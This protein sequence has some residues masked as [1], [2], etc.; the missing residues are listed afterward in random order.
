L[1]SDSG[2]LAIHGLLNPDM[3]FD[4]LPW[5]PFHPGVDI[6]ELYPKTD[7]EGHAALLRYQPGTCVPF[8]LHR[9]YEHI[10]VLRGSQRDSLGV[11]PAGTLVIKQPDTSH[12]VCSDEGCVVLAIWHRPVRILTEE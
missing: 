4:A 8:H 11:Y 3:D 9:G 6:V 5:Q 10:L 12:Q 7:E 2:A 1:I